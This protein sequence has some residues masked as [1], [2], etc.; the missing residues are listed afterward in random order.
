MRIF[1][2]NAAYSLLRFARLQKTIINLK[3]SNIIIRVSER[4]RERERA[5][6]RN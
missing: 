4:E 1:V 6:N 5:M 3:V 2:I